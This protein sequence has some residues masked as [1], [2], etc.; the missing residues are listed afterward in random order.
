[1]LRT[2]WVL[3]AVGIDAAIPQAGK[4]HRMPHRTVSRPVVLMFDEPKGES[5]APVTAPVAK[6][7]VDLSGLDFE[8][9]LAVLAAQV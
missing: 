3:A 7:E 1:M 8:E 4:L 5:T 2:L 9:R 6:G